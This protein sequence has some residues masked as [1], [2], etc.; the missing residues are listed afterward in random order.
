[1]KHLTTDKLLSLGMALHADKRTMEHRVRSIFARRHSAWFASLA[2]VVLCG[3]I[4]VLG[5]TTACQPAE[6]EVFQEAELDTFAGRINAVYHALCD[7]MPVYQYAE[8]QDE[9]LLY[10]KYAELAYD[11]ADKNGDDPKIA[12]ERKAL[13]TV[14]AAAK[15]APTE[16]ELALRFDILAYPD[17]I[18]EVSYGKNRPAYFQAFLDPKLIIQF[19]NHGFV[20]PKEQAERL[21]LKLKEKDAIAEAETILAK[22]GIGTA[23]ELRSIEEYVLDEAYYQIYLDDNT[24]KHAYSLVYEE[25]GKTDGD[26]IEVRIDD[27]GLLFFEWQM[28]DADLPIHGTDAKGQMYTAA[29]G[30]AAPRTTSLSLQTADGSEIELS[31]IPVYVP[32]TGTFYEM[33]LEILDFDVEIAKR[34]AE[35]FFEDDLGYIPLNSGAITKG[36]HQKAIEYLEE[37]LATGRYEIEYDTAEQVRDAIREAKAELPKLPDEFPLTDEPEFRFDHE[38]LFLQSTPDHAVTRTLELQTN[39]RSGGRILRYER[40]SWASTWMDGLENEVFRDSVSYEYEPRK[41]QR[42]LD[43]NGQAAKRAMKDLQ[44]DESYNCVAYRLVS[45]REGGAL[46]E[47]I[48]TKRI[49]GAEIPYAKTMNRYGDPNVKVMES[50]RI[51]VEEDDV[52]MI[53]W[54]SPSE[55]KGGQSEPLVLLPFEQI[56]ANAEAVLEHW[57]TTDTIRDINLS[58]IALGYMR[59]PDPLMGNE[60]TLTPVKE[61][62]IPVWDFYGSCVVTDKDQDEYNEEEYIDFGGF[63]SLVTV[64]AVTGEIMYRDVRMERWGA[65]S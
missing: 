56:M 60:K 58:R 59:V 2:A 25:I 47:F 40:D 53:V 33:E 16:K 8:T 35:T 36:Y 50:I 14:R 54:R 20:E 18:V 34:F 43:R 15:T 23:F 37:Q 19:S 9:M 61:K 62:L 44:L 4:G 29:R 7:G 32:E 30:H 21:P 17:H 28:A 57:T 64:N 49:D 63:A 13:D 48:Y 27:N 31:N 51:W 46:H 39:Y 65:S 22:I 45:N 3:M 38:M 10:V 12:E 5:F 52:M 55:I 11:I 24:K 6:E 42:E 26:K 1:M 41:V